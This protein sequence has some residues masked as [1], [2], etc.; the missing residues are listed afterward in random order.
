MNLCKNSNNRTVSLGSEIL[1]GDN[2]AN[3][4][5]LK[6]IFLGGGGTNVLLI[7]CQQEI[8]IYN[9]CSSKDSDTK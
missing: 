8:Y 5:N 2:Y 9:K 4:R 6:I 1:Y 3:Y 7:R